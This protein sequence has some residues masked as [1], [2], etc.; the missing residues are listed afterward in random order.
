MPKVR[1][2][3]RSRSHTLPPLAKSGFGAQITTSTNVSP[4]AVREAALGAGVVLAKGMEFNEE[5]FRAFVSA[6]GDKVSYEDDDAAVGYGVSDLLHLD[7]TRDSGKVITGRGPLPLHTDGVLLGTQVDLIVLYAVEADR[8]Q[9]DG[10]TLV[11]D[12]ISAWHDMPAELRSV[13][14]RGYLEYKAIELGYFTSV[15]TDWY[16]IPTFRDYGRVKSLN[17]ALP[18]AENVPAS[19]DARVPGASNADSRSFFTALHHHLSHERYLYQHRWEQGDLL[20]I[21]NQQTL[22]GRDGLT[23][24][25]TRKLLRGQVTLTAATEAPGATT[26]GF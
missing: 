12:Q 26:K 4:S 10:A 3:I 9:G 17:I 20:V 23:D 8:L 19:W 15:P 13:L 21:D 2:M 25:A 5:S 16:S 1:N 11:C 7:G 6:L 24:T 22:H 14:A 18:F